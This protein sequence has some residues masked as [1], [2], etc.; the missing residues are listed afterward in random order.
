MCVCVCVCLCVSQALVDLDR[1]KMGHATRQILAHAIGATAAGGEVGVELRLSATING[2][3]L[4]TGAAP[5]TSAASAG[6]RASLRDD[7]TTA[8][9]APLGSDPS[10][11]HPSAPGVGAAPTGQQSAQRLRSLVEAHHA[12]QTVL[13][14]MRAALRRGSSN[15][16]ALG[17]GLGDMSASPRVAKPKYLV[18]QV[19]AIQPIYNPYLIPI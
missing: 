2:A 15:L 1:R 4:A 19:R 3:T 12:R 14:R 13:G 6:H 10:L 16:G 5:G 17:A 18:V 9:A 11:P 7:D 8:A